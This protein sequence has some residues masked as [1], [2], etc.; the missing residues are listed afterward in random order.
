MEKNELFFHPWIS[1]PCH[2]KKRGFL[3]ALFDLR[4]FQGVQEVDLGF[5]VPL[6][7]LLDSIGLSHFNESKRE[8]AGIL[9]KHTEVENGDVSAFP[10]P[11]LKHIF[12]FTAFRGRRTEETHCFRAPSELKC[13]VEVVPRGLVVLELE[14]FVSHNSLLRAPFSSRPLLSFTA[15][16][17]SLPFLSTN[18]AQR[19]CFPSGFKI[20]GNTKHLLGRKLRMVV[21][22]IYVLVR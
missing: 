10:D 19:K 5:W 12:F 1:K 9:E 20:L 17:L 13:G 3:C 21:L 15:L 8:R 11:H 4:D 16:A 7:S 2:L 18:K 14:C 6:P 22:Y